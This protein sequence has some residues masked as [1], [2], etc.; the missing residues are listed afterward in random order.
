MLP[1]VAAQLA[2]MT[3][4]K[5]KWDDGGEDSAAPEAPSLRTEGGADV[6]AMDAAGT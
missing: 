4:R 3:E 6:N 5:R 2:K 1:P